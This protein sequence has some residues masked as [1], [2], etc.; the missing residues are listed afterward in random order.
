MIATE[1][2]G[3]LLQYYVP[4]FS[5]CWLAGFKNRYGI[6]SQVHQG[7]AGAVDVDQLEHNLIGI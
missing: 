6:K 7:E 3:K 2:W 4:Q 5:V 1:F